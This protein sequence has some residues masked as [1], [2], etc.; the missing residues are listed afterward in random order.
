MVGGRKKEE[1][2]KGRGEGEKVPKSGN[3]DSCLNV[4]GTL[5][6]REAKL[7]IL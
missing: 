6:A 3:S 5:A 4:L 2:R 7:G 1:Q